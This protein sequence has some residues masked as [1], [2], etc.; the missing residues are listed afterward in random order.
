[1]QANTHTQIFVYGCDAGP[2][3]PPT[4]VVLAEHAKTQFEHMSQVP[5]IK[6]LQKMAGDVDLGKC[7]YLQVVPIDTQGNEL[8]P[9]KPLF[10]DISN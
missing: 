1:M 8:T 9:S 3:N 2:S 5:H 7:C 10:V 4:E 6:V